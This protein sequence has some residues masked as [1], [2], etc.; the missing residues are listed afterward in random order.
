LADSL[1]DFGPSR[2]I[3]ISNLPIAIVGNSAVDFTLM[4]KQSRHMQV[5][6]F[7]AL[8]H[9]FLISFDHDLDQKEHKLN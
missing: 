7:H 5:V 9:L 3:R 4:P 6:R 1:S 2:L 8:G